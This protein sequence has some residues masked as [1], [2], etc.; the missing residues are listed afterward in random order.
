MSKE[1]KRY[2]P[3]I[4]KLL[5]DIMEAVS[6]PVEKLRLKRRRFEFL[7]VNGLETYVKD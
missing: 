5:I 2:S 7:K 1:S 3:E 4:V 6:L